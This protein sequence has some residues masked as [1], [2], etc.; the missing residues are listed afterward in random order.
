[1]VDTT[2]L[3][4]CHDAGLENNGHRHI[5]TMIE[6]TVDRFAS[7]PSLNG[8]YRARQDMEWALQDEDTYPYFFG[9]VRIKFD[10]PKVGRREPTYGRRREKWEDFC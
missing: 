8:M 10:I 4:G 3:F 5:L 7:E 2:I 9:A 6:R 1:M